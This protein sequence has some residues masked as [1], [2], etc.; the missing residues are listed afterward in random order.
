MLR[1]F[2]TLAEELRAPRFNL[3]PA[4]VFTS[5]T[6]QQ[7][8]DLLFSASELPPSVKEL[9][10][11]G[12]QELPARRAA[13]SAFRDRRTGSAWFAGLFMLGLM[14]EGV[15]RLFAERALLFLVRHKLGWLVLGSA[16]TF[17]LVD[18]LGDDTAGA[19]LLA[20]GLLLVGAGF[21]ISYSEEGLNGRRLTAYFAGLTG[22]AAVLLGVATYFGDGVR[23]LFGASVDALAG[24]EAPRPAKA[25]RADIH[26]DV[27]NF[28]NT[29]MEG[30]GAAPPV[31]AA[32]PAPAPAPAQDFAANLAQHERALGGGERIEQL[33]M[34]RQSTIQII[35]GTS[36]RPPAQAEPQSEPADAPPA[37]LSEQAKA[38]VRVRA[39]FPETL[40][41]APSVVTDPQGNASLEIP[42]ADSIT[43]WRAAVTASSADG[44]LGT[45]QAALK[46]FQDFFVDL[47]LPPVLTVGDEVAV[48]I[49]VHNHLDHPEQ[50]TV[51]VEPADWM[52]STAPQT[53]ALQLQPGQVAG[54]SYRFKAARFGA[55][56][57]LTVYA[58]GPHGKDAVRREVEVRPEGVPF[59]TVENGTAARGVH[60]HLNL[61][62]GAV[63]GA[64]H[65]E[66]RLYPSTFAAVMDGLENVLRMPSGCFEQTSSTT[67]P[68]ALVL[69]YL[70][71]SKKGTPELLARGEGY[72]TTG[73]QR[74]LSFEVQGGGFEWFGRAPANQV[75]TAYGLLEFQDIA[76]VF[77]VDPAV[78]HRT[79]EYLVQRQDYDGSW[80]ADAQ[81]LSDGLYRDAF[82]G[83]L[84]TTAYV[85]WALVESGYR[86]EATDRAARFLLAHVDAQLDGYTL[87]LIA[88]ALAGL[89]ASDG[90]RALDLLLQRAGGRDTLHVSAGTSTVT[91]PD[92]DDADVEAT[93]LTA[94]ALLKAHRGP[95]AVKALKWLLS[96]RDPH[97][98]W[99]STQ[100][101]VLALRAL[102]EAAGQEGLTT[103]QGTLRVVGPR[104]AKEIRFTPDQAD[105]V[106]RVDLTDWLGAGPVELSFEGEAESSYQLQVSGYRA[107]DRRDRPA[108]SLNLTYDKAE[109][110]VDDTVEAALTITHQDEGPS[111]MALIQAAIPP[112]FEAVTADLEKLV[113]AR[114]VAKYT[115]DGKQLTFYVDRLDRD[116]PLVLRYALRAKFPV[117]A[118]AP[119]SSA[120]LY[121]QPSTHAESAPQAL[122]VAAK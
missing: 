32:M 69:R 53:Y 68:N 112:G 79:Q 73:M 55:H 17:V 67:Y 89:H 60:A 3:D 86:G 65:A 93:A 37:P 5:G 91:S 64:S 90:A 81:S 25:Q 58:V 42:G 62:E 24:E 29:A 104:G 98:T 88:N 9:G 48:P 83:R 99:S 72:L 46:V 80:S 23:G 85:T 38:E 33:R 52:T 108:L 76:K 47:D 12:E 59:E 102:L 26:R 107:A 8:A 2:L 27:T 113:A 122:S 77:D 103:A 94:S 97:G 20:V 50:V 31:A 15:L 43:T 35:K 96:V 101:T 116:R 19:A 22:L 21:L 100:A 1:A 74:L 34:R 18:L 14:L 87:A 11:T 92:G 70:R 63:P 115:S 39:F 28:S 41:W 57:P 13:L 4:A 45:G 82:H 106:Q 119:S 66:L 51:E 121:Y 75:L 7:A 16:G 54:I 114:Q 61:P 118:T 95:E 56:Q 78:I 120:Y 117:R 30:E 49:A 6:A 110:R 84:T 44:R 10:H 111:G 36:E 71:E 105:V 40:F 109:L